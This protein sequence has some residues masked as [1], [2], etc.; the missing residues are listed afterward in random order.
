MHNVFK[1]WVTQL[2][3]YLQFSQHP[4]TWRMVR[5]Y[6]QTQIWNSVKMR[7]SYTVK[8]QPLWALASTFRNENFCSLTGAGHATK[9]KCHLGQDPRERGRQNKWQIKSLDQDDVPLISKTVL[10]LDLFVE[11]GTWW[12]CPRGAQRNAVSPE[13]K[14]KV[15]EFQKETDHDTRTGIP[16]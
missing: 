8:Q 9:Q 4:Q 12:Q 7:L 2:L 11:G 1:T 14:A 10:C 15:I 16:V 13:E 6:Q 3:K 5:W